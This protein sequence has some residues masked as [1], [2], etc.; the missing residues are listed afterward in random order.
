[1]VDGKLVTVEFK[2]EN[3]SEIV[4]LKFPSILAPSLS[5]PP[6]QINPIRCCIFLQLQLTNFFFPRKLRNH[7]LPYWTSCLPFRNCRVLCLRANWRILWMSF[8]RSSTSLSDGFS[9]PTGN[10][11]HNTTCIH[12]YWYFPHIERTCKDCVVMRRLRSLLRTFS[13]WWRVLLQ[14]QKRSSSY[15]RNR[16]EDLFMPSMALPSATGIVCIYFFLLCLLFCL[17]FF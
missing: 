13:S 8:T 1:M 11:T 9:A 2:P 16:K 10:Q 3:P 17:F 6:S 4:R 15:R 14:R 5:P 7:R 12:L